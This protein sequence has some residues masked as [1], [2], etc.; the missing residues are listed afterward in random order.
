[1][2]RNDL[3][4]EIEKRIRNKKKGILEIRHIYPIEE[5]RDDTFL[6]GGAVQ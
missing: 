2:S 4:I 1:M 6:F 5:L 3:E